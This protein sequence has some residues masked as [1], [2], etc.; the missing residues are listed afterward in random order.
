MVLLL[1]GYL[2][3]HIWEPA[4]CTLDATCKICGK[5]GNQKL[6][7]DWMDATCTEKATCL[8]C[9]AQ[10]GTPLGH[11]WTEATCWNPV[12]CA[13][14]GE[15]SGSPLEHICTE[16]DCTTPAVC[17][18]CGHSFGDALGHS[19]TDPTF[20]DA[21]VCLVCGETV[22]DPINYWDL[23]LTKEF[24]HVKDLYDEI[25]ANQQAGVYR[26]EILRKGVTAY[27]DDNGVLKKLSITRGTDGI[28]SYSDD[29]GRSYYLE[30]GKP[31]F[32]F[33]QGDDAHRLYF[34][35]GLL[36]RWRY[37]PIGSETSG[38]V[39]HDFTF[40]D[41]YMMLERLAQQEC[42]MYS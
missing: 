33:Y 18:V 6:G 5:T 10:K 7:H 27:Y 11:N 8:R 31:V 19:L 37:N 32:A 36:M 26:K 4:T 9:Q 39:N 14:C 1:V 41:T 3:I 34:Y 17:T 23:D 28:G 22:G 30:D 38:A 20:L 16:P 21:P 2:T 29:Y 40:S 12:T 35:K 42:A 13:V 24:T 15:T 25:L